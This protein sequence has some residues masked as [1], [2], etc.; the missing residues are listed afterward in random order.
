MKILIVEDE[1]VLRETMVDQLEKEGYRCE[2]A[3]DLEQSL[4]KIELYQ[5]EIVLLDVGLPDGNGLEVLN[6]LK[7]LHPETGV[8]IISA[9][10]ALEDK[11]LGLREGADDYLTKPFH[12]PEL[13]A[14]IKSL[15]RRRFFQGNQIIEFGSLKIDLLSNTIFV[16]DK[17]VELNKKEYDLL[18]FFVMNKNRV[19]TKA[20]IAEHLWGDYMDLADNFDLVY[21]HV[22]NLR[23]R[24]LQNGGEDYI[25]TIYGMG[26]KLS[27]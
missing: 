6:R 23:K 8:V 18:L 4:E 13:N 2:T 14:R 20:A 7:M 12:F 15:I 19:L 10:H 11:V 21:T 22:K 24:I 3:I 5:Y 16:L 17:A 27:I 25:K 9:R 1:T 26:Y